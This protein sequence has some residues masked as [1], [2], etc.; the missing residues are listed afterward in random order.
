MVV[1]LVA[2][3][4]WLVYGHVGNA[5]MLGDQFLGEFMCQL[6]PLCGVEL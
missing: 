3:F 6:L 2:L 4:A 1:A 5:A